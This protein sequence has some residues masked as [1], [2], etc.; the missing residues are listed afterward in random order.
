MD[1]S[2]ERALE[3]DRLM[4]ETEFQNL[5]FSE[6]LSLVIL[7]GDEVVLDVGTGTGL[8]AEILADKLKEGA[9]FGVDQSPAMLR[10]AQEKVAQKKL[11]NYYL[12]KSP[13]EELVFRD[14]LFDFAFCVRALHHFAD[15]A[16]AL[17]EINRVLKSEGKLVMC[18]P[19]GPEDE[20]LKQILTEAFQAAHPEYKF[21]GEK[22]LYS[23]F[24]QAGF[25]ET[26]ATD[27]VL[28]FDQ[29]GVG[30]IPMGP[31]YLQ[32]YHLIRWRGN[33]ELLRRFEGELFQVTEREDLVHVRGKLKFLVTVLAK[34]KK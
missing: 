1:I 24:Q 9:I 22:D 29:D 18:E 7:K 5:L 34:G 26:Q 28:A 2:Y 4:R 20:G 23:L 19:L 6:M 30:G 13:A 21:F 27:M 11:H 15:Q 8:L 3:M 32:A 14:A 33:Q 12:L 16:M 31:H 17:K 25:A 10:V